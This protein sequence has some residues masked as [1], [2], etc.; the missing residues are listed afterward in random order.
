[1]VSDTEAA[2]VIEGSP[3][4][5]LFSTVAVMPSMIMQHNWFGQCYAR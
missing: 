3:I 5:A 1:M 4:S 2:N